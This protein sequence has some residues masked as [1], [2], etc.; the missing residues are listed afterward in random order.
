MTPLHMLADLRRRGVVLI[1]QG[2]RLHVDAPAGVLTPEMRDALAAHKYELLG[3]LLADDP[4]VVW[5]I[6]AMRRQVP[7]RGPIPFLVARDVPPVP[8][9]CLSCG[10]ALALDQPYRCRPCVQAA[11]LA[12]REARQ[13]LLGGAPDGD[14]Q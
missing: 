6:D 4:E 14:R 10:D 8:G 3:L 12:L 1:A 11:I 7:L 13:V 9:T 2:D 5:R